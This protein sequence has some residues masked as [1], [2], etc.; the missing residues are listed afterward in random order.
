MCDFFAIEAWDLYEMTY[1]P[2]HKLNYMLAILN[3]W[4]GIFPISN[5][6]PVLFLTYIIQ[7]LASQ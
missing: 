7:D 5:G 1:V 3:P 4:P 6:F 2:S